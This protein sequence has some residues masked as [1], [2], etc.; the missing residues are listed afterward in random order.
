MVIKRNSNSIGEVRLVGG[1]EGYN[2]IFT[3]DLAIGRYMSLDEISGGRNIAIIGHEVANALFP[4]GADPT[5]QSVKIKNLKFTVIGVTKKEGESFMGTPS[6]D[7]VVIIPYSAYRKLFQ[8]GSG[9]WDENQSSIGI[10]GFPSDVGLV[11][12][13]NEV[14]GMMRVK[15]GIEPIE[16]DNFAINRP[17]ALMKIIGSV[18][19]VF[20]FAGW[21]IGGMAMLVGGFGIANIMFVSVQERIPII[22]LQKSLGAKNYVILLQF[23]FESIFLS[24]IGGLTGL[25]IVYVLT[26]LP[27]ESVLGSLVVKLSIENIILGLIVSSVIGIVSGIIPAARAAGLD[28]VDALRSS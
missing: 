25:F 9:R 16:K 2:D 28:P 22:G 21:M 7:F 10:K 24:L 14:R 20:S 1:S 8:T 26:I 15:R 4:N 17:E 13:E 12:L 23:L 11:E 5:N 3:V 19:D 6:N 18:F 27:L